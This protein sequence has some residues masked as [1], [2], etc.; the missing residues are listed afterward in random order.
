VDM[1]CH[2]GVCSAGGYCVLSL[3]Y[4][5]WVLRDAGEKLGNRVLKK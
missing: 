1:R 3:R 2:S 5:V 4:F